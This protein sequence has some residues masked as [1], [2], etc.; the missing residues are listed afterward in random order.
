[1]FIFLL[2]TWVGGQAN[3]FHQYFLCKK[4]IKILTTAA[5][6]LGY[7][8]RTQTILPSLG[9]E[10]KPIHNTFCFSSTDG[11]GKMVD[12]KRVQPR[13]ILNFAVTYM[14]RYHWVVTLCT[15]MVTIVLKHL[16]VTKIMGVSPGN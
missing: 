7:K 5:S 15:F 3:L 14:V 6:L 10:G 16:N 13:K 9:Y 4:G 8:G 11:H 1:L 2:H 12:I